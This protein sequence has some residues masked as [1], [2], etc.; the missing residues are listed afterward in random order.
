VRT[1]NFHTHTNFCDGSAHPEKYVKKAISRRFRA[2]GFSAHAPLPIENSWSLKQEK[3]P[4]YCALIGQLR[5][6]YREKIEIYLSM[7]IDY[8]PGMTKDFAAMKEVFNLDYTLGGIHLV[9][10]PE[11]HEIWFIDGPVGNYD[12]GLKTIFKSDIKLAV[13][14]Y[15]NQLN[16]MIKTQNPDIVA[17]FD[18]IKMN[19][20]NRYF[21]EKDP[22]YR[23]LIEETVWLIKQQGCIAEVN[24][25]GLYTGKY[26]DFYP[27]TWVLQLCCSQGVPLCISADAHR[28][29]EISWFF[30]KAE[31]VL[32]KT[33]YKSIR[34]LVGGTWTDVEL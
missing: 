4:E 33:G 30:K 18:K 6:K 25:R 15:F 19:N 28:P 2:L 7:E 26:K 32:K 34:T 12:N 27:G 31:R 20:R 29:W 9:K 8:I 14:T 22:W 21:N 16:Q 1:S 17:H 10:N 5:E 24:T 11:N 13:K 3:A 23:A